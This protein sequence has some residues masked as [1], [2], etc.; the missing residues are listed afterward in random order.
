MSEIK[1]V[2]KSVFR[3]LSE[4]FIYTTDSENYG[5]REHWDSH[6]DAVRSGQV[7]RGDCDDFAA[8]AMAL[9]A[10]HDILSMLIYCKTE[11]GGGHLVCGVE[12]GSHT[13]VIDNRQ[14]GVW[15]WT[16]IRYEWVS[17]L[18]DGVWRKIA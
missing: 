17:A 3:Q 12:D 15:D 2:C 18:R 1:D 16:S 14:R 11:N 7:W 6:E 13:W 9:L 10:E 5:L 8:T 4:N